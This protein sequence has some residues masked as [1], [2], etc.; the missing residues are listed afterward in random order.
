MALGFGVGL[1][2]A[3]PGTAATLWAWVVYL[4]LQAFLRAEEIGVV[5][6]ISTIVGWW[7]CTV[8]AEHLMEKDPGA[9][10]WD[11]V[12]AFHSIYGSAT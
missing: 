10:V 8:T 6:L 2:R 5:I 12:V 1:S 4:I 7:A 11:E 3:A 9:I